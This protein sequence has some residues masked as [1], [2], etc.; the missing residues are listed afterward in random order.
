MKKPA[1]RYLVASP[2]GD[3]P[4]DDDKLDFPLEADPLKTP[5]RVYFRSI[6]DFLLGNNCMPLLHSLNTAP[7]AEIQPH[8][9]EEIVVRTEK[10]GAL[11]HPASIEVVCRENRRK[12]GLNVAVTD[13]GKDFLKREFT[14]L[15]MLHEKFSLPYIPAPYFL[16]ELDSMVFLIEEWFEGYHE[17]HIANTQNGGQKVKVWEYGKGDRFLSP[18]ESAEIYRQASRIL[19]LYYDVKNFRLIYPWH[20]AAGDFVVRI[21]DQNNSPSPNPSHQGRGNKRD[22]FRQGKGHSF[23]IP[24]PLVGEGEGEGYFQDKIDVRLTTVRGYELFLNIDEDT[25]HPALALFYFLLHL[26]IQMR[27]DKL[28]GVGDTA[29]ADDGCVDATLAGFFH[30]LDSRKDFRECCGSAAE[31]LNLLRSFGRDDLKTTFRAVAAQFERTKD[32][33]VIEKYLEDHIG[34]FFLTLQNFP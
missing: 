5:Y 3:V 7:G 9:I 25:V 1:I 16:D 2:Y 19:T 34:R 10:H 31:F 30:G 22:V 6:S 29:W 21:E 8:D 28:D 18:E 23:L 20:H 17:F 27:L 24:S 33:P 14:L 13:T 12:F 26:S 11:Y 32:F 4:V 15:T